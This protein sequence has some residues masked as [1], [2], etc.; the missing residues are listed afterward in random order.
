MS[1]TFIQAERDNYS[2]CCHLPQ[3]KFRKFPSK[4][5]DEIE[6]V[7]SEVQERILNPQEASA[8]SFT[9]FCYRYVL[10]HR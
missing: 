6:T 10:G 1:P 9:N 5:E 7:T 4:P 8:I 3:P 2:P